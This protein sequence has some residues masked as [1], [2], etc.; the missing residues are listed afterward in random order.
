MGM[1]FLVQLI[2]KMMHLKLFLMQ[3]YQWI[4]LVTI[5]GNKQGQKLEYSIVYGLTNITLH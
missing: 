2:G 4:R 1:L 3:N 5:Y